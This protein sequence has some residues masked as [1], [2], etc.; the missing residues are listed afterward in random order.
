MNLSFSKRE[1]ELAFKQLYEQYYA[2][3]CLYAKRF[4]ENREER[5]DIVSEVFATLWNKIDWGEVDAQ[6]ATVLGYIKMSVKNSCLN[7]LK[8]Q[9]YEWDYS[10]RMQKLAPIYDENYDSVYTLDELYQMLLETLEKLPENYR[11]VFKKSFFE[12]K[13]HAEIAEEMNISL[14]SVGR[15]K[16]KVMDFLQVE[17]KDY[18]P[19]IIYSFILQ[20]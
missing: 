13:T 14:K 4:V 19:L 5:E 7:Y 11:E 18:L 15:Y 2:P 20:K 1:K 17:L 16:Q 9:E 10:E 6:S 3:F 8:H 12:E